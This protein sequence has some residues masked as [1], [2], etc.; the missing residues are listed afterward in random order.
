MSL[1][2]KLG[3]LYIW[4]WVVS[5]FK[6]GLSL[7]LKLGCLY[8]S[9]WVVSTF[10]IGL[11]LSISNCQFLFDYLNIHSFIGWIIIIIIIIIIILIMYSFSLS[12]ICIF[13]HSFLHLFSHSVI[14]Y[15]S[16]WWK[17]YESNME[18]CL[19]ISHWK[20]L[21]DHLFFLF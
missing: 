6:I 3:C 10:Q 20:Y 18:G 8:I 9:N 15:T 16:C 2:L 14:I 17:G 12:F 21:L 7:Y 4:T 19:Y 1:Y 11:S 5:I 13:N